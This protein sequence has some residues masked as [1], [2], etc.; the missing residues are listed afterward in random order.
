MTLGDD[1]TL[2][3][4]AAAWFARM[5][6][7][8]AEAARADFD[9]WRAQPARQMAYD[10]LIR[11]FDESAILGHSRLADLRLQ[12]TARRRA[13]AGPW[14]PA[15]IAAGLALAAFAVWRGGLLPLQ[16]ASPEAQRFVAAPGQIRKVEVAP[17]LV[18]V[19]D[20][21]S[22]LS[23]VTDKGRPRLT[24]ERG[25]VRIEA[26]GPVEAHVAETRLN[27]TQGAFDLRID[28]DRGLELAALRGELLVSAQGGGLLAR[29]TVR[30]A[31][32]QSLSLGQGRADAPTR[33]SIRDRDWPQGLLI[34]DE[35]P[36]EQVVAEANRY[37]SRKIRL[38]D[39]DLARL[40][41]SGGLRVTDPENLARTLAAA[42]GLTV[43]PAG[44]DLVLRR[45]GA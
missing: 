1:E 40:P 30:L 45:G 41:V 13:G 42:L 26:T 33:L 6:G 22:A 29:R 31:P 16:P 5:R 34:C 3:R 17:G 28:P 19:I 10:R 32:G 25:R 35:T 18:A 7:P 36:L 15:A 14:L 24:L 20:T 43:T 37:G 4:E 23:A 38:A 11:R 21:D 44:G 27:A 2:R 39:G 12:P 9:A 8:G